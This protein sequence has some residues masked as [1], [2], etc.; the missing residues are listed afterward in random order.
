MQI[1]RTMKSWNQ[2]YPLKF[3]Q[4]ER[5]LRE[6]RTVL[7]II[8][9]KEIQKIVTTIPEPLND[10]ELLLFLKFHHEIREI[11]YFEDIPEYIILDTQ[12]LADG[13]KCI[14]TADDFQ[15]KRLQNKDEWND[16][17]QKGKL[18][19][20]VIE[21]IYTNLKLFSQHKTHILKVMEKFNIIIHCNK[22]IDSQKPCYY[23]PCM[24]KRE[25]KEDIHEMFEITDDRKSLWLCF[26]FT[27]LP[28]HLMNHL[29]ASLHREY[30][31][32]EV[33]GEIALFKNMVVFYLD[34]K[35]L[36]KLLVASYANLIQIQIWKSGEGEGSYI[37]IANNVTE[38]LSNIVKIRF[39][40]TNVPFEKKLKCST[41]TYDSTVGLTKLFGDGETYHCKTCN[42]THNFNDDWSYPFR[43]QVNI[44]IFLAYVIAFAQSFN[45]FKS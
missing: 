38:E 8:S 15:R 29:V 21:D 12:W 43:K 27:F 35:G 4:L 42:S 20:A 17:N 41:A 26:A 3:I 40:L 31:F 32:V 10:E 5:L 7:P 2:D 13:F 22:S 28:P 11:V 39:K 19:Q 37:H 6:K 14:V 30:E 33:F 25:L 9:F 36:H 45:M 16:F 18:S 1:A 23:V 44:D 34:E 24:I